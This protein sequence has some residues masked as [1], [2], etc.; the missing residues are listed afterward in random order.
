[1]R[2]RDSRFWYLFDEMRFP[3]S[4]RFRVKGLCYGSCSQKALEFAVGEFWIFRWVLMIGRNCYDD[5]GF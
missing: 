3:F 5:G 4:I 2:F 1:M